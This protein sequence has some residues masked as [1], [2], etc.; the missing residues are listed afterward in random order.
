MRRQVGREIAS[1]AR[2]ATPETSV[3]SGLSGYSIE[4]EFDRTQMEET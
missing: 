1:A 2:N 4:F 3:V